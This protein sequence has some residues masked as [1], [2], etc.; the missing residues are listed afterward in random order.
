MIY[1]LLGRMETRG[2]IEGRWRESSA[3]MMKTYHLTGQGT[4]LLNREL[5]AAGE[6]QGWANLVLGK[7]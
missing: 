2:A 6:L 3:A 5:A 4:K 7:C 1:G